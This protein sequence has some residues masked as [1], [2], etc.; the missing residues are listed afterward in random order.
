MVELLTMVMR[1]AGGPRNAQI[2]KTCKEALGELQVADCTVAV[3]M[4]WA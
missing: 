4:A 2:R 3:P 1:E